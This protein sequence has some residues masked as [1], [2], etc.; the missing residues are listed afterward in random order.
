[1]CRSVFFLREDQMA[2]LFPIESP[3]AW[4]SSVMRDDA[5]WLYQLDSDDIFELK[6]ALQDCRQKNKN[7]PFLVKEDFK[8]PG[9]AEKIGNIKSQLINGRG[10]ALIR[11]LPVLE[12]SKEDAGIIFWGIGAH[13]GR[14]TAQN[15]YGDVLGHVWNLGRDHTTDTS[16]RGYQSNLRLNF[17]TDTTDVVGLLCLRKAKRG[18]LSSVASSAAIHNELLR[19]NQALLEVLYKN[20]YW[21][22][23]D[24]E[25]EGELPYIVQPVFINN[26]NRVFGRFVDRYIRSAQRFET[27][28]RLTEL[29]VEALDAV[30]A[31]ANS[32]K[33][34]LDMDLQP[35]DMQFLMNYSVLHSRTAYED[36]PELD[37][38]RHLLRLWLF[39]SEFDAN[40]PEIYSQRNRIVDAWLKVPRAPI[41]DVKEIMGVMGD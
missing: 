2:N 1:M 40:R 30:A 16:S 34:R 18:G 15:A 23:R 39:C 24:E 12:L 21:D 3:A 31:L 8:I 29:Q 35:G 14:A 37:R 11:G 28:P 25:P 13:L 17:H 7:I 6:A 19:V 5:S 4:T 27:V 32:D 26:M 41:Y 38:K 10:V 20:F 9:L 22:Q 33:F 36:F